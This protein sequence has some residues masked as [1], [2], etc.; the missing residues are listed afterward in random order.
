MATLFHNWSSHYDTEP[1]GRKLTRLADT[2]V[3]VGDVHPEHR[4]ALLG[5]LHYIIRKALDLVADVSDDIE[6]ERVS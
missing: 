4:G 6:R 2:Y 1:I 3:S 5:D